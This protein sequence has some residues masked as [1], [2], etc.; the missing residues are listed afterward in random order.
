MIQNQLVYKDIQMHETLEGFQNWLKA[1]ALRDETI[2][3]YEI[4]IKQSM[5]FWSR[6]TNGPL[7]VNELEV[8]HVDELIQYFINERN[9][10]PKTVNRK[11]NSLSTYFLYLKKQKMI[12]DN[13]LDDYD[14]MKVRDKER[15]YLTKDEI[16]K[17]I[18]EI[19]HPIIRYFVITMA[20]TGIRVKECINLTLNDVDI[21]EGFLHVV[22]GK[23]G[24]NRTVPLNNYLQKELREYLDY[25]RPYTKSLYFFATKKTGTISEQYVNRILKE[26]TQKAGIDKHV[27]SHILRHSFAS[28]L[29]KKD[30]NVAVIQKLLGHSSLKTTSIYLHVQQDDLIDAVNRIDY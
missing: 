13:P 27:T 5:D 22:N 16:E 10:Q 9:V 3:G 14:R 21:N 19:D 1:R 20:N 6:N 23:G 12:M 18:E 26:A 2:R 4:D 29:V 30:T 24:K 17:I 8:K 25:C 11:L 15:I 28:Y 7:F